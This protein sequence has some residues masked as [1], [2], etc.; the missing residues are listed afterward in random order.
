MESMYWS[1]DTTFNEDR[2]RS[3]KD[4]ASKN[5]SQLLRLSYDILKSYGNQEKMPLKRMRKKAM[6]DEAYLEMLVAAVF[7]M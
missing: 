1:L 3:K 2:R 6:V 7:G 4:N 5:L